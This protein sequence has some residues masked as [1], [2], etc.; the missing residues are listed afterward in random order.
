M[1]GFKRRGHLNPVTVPKGASRDQLYSMLASVI[2]QR[3]AAVARSEV[4]ATELGKLRQR[5]REVEA[6]GGVIVI[7]TE[8]D[9]EVVRADDRSR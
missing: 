9:K 8:W 3:N 7:P 2:D 1:S 5:M 4:W 6:A